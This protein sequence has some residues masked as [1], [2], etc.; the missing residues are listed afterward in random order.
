MRGEITGRKVFFGFVAAF[1]V[2]IG[3]NV[4][5]AVQA[6]RTFPGLEV[7]NSYVASQVF[8]RDRKAQEALGW[9]LRES[10][11]NG[12]L[13]LA[14]RD[15]AGR[16]VALRA[17]TATVGRTTM[18]ADDV[19]PDFVFEGGDYVARVDLAPGKWM[20]HVR[21]EAPDG[22]IFQ[23]RLDLFVRG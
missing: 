23:Q 11:E 16:P 21:A 3:V 20:I 10:H 7:P 1:T 14:F 19:T 13:R 15:S 4:L 9:V 22:T 17:L 8:D 18:A 12:I 5:M 2:I 6:I